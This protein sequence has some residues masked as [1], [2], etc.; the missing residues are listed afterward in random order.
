MS[1]ANA[2]AGILANTNQ[3]WRIGVGDL[4]WTYFNGLIDEI[5][6]FNVPLAEQDIQSILNKGLKESLG[7]AAVDLSGK[8]TTTWA[9]I[10]AR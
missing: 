9:N 2:S 7:L 4:S 3:V 8:L 1:Q 5:A 6:V 10:K